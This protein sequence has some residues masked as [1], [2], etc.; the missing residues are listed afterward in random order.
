MR[1]T[2]DVRL[3]HRGPYVLVQTKVLGNALDRI[4]P[5]L[6]T[7]AVEMTFGG[8][9]CVL[10]VYALR[11]AEDLGY[12]FPLG[13]MGWLN[14]LPLLFILLFGAG[15]A[16]LLLGVGMGVLAILFPSSRRAG[17]IATICCGFGLIAM[18]APRELQRY[19]YGL[20]G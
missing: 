16:S 18:T 20:L 9:V 11:A 14:P 4:A 12:S 8:L 13:S 3:R 7:F 10:V 1:Q 15:V 19:V 17:L 6:A 5:R 2:A